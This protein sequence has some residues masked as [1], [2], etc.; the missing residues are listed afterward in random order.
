MLIVMHFFI[1]AL[2][3]PRC[4]RRQRRPS[5]NTSKYIYSVLKLYNLSHIYLFLK[6]RGGWDNIKLTRRRRRRRRRRTGG[7]KKTPVGGSRRH[8]TVGPSHLVCKLPAPYQSSLA[9]CRR[10]EQRNGRLIIGK[11]HWGGAPS[12][13]STGLLALSFCTAVYTS[14]DSTL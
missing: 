2:G 14:T 8:A 11:P 4:F 12:V 5:T 10:R 13:D 9:V 3:L 7:I 1:C 6:E